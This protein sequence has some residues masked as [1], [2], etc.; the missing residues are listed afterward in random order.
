MLN[1]SKQVSICECG[2]HCFS[3]ITKG[4]TV[5]VSPEDAKFL[6]RNR[7]SS[8]IDKHSVYAQ[9]SALG[10][11]VRLHREIMRPTAG[12][13][14]DHINGNGLDNRRTNLRIATHAQNSVNRI[15]FRKSKSGFVGVYREKNRWRATINT[16]RGHINLGSYVTPE[17]AAK[18]RDAAAYA[19]YG[20][21][22]QLNFPLPAS[23]GASE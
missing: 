1:P 4:Y 3:E 12:H 22:A 15:N 13:L 20:E 5:I 7:W 21:F 6:D 2:N 14:V 10:K 16:E 19:K 18:V 23:P 11:T 8:K 9:R 17:E